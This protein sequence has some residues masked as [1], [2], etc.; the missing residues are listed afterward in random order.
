[1]EWGDKGC[2]YAPSKCEH[3]AGD[4]CMW[5]CMRCNT[6][7]HFCPGCG[8]VSDHKDTLCEECKVFYA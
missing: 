2:E 8:T 5:C 3:E 4:G 6:D 1:M 7:T